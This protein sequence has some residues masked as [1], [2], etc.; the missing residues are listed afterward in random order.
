MARIG[1][2]FINIDTL[3]VLSRSESGGALADG[4]TVLDLTQSVVTFH[5]IARID[6]F[7][8]LLVASAILR[9]IFVLDTINAEAAYF[10]IVRIASGSWRAGARWLMIN[11]CTE[12]VTTAG[13]SRAGVGASF[14][15]AL[16][17]KT[18]QMVC[19]RG[20]GFTFVG[21]DASFAVAIANGSRSARAAER[22]ERVGTLSGRVTWSVQAF[23]NID[24][25]SVGSGSVARSATALAVSTD[26]TIGAIGI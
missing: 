3:V 21:C 16:T 19:T 26:L 5:R 1:A 7:E 10:R 4:F 2:A 12:G 23:V 15:A 24:A 8:R 13:R 20:A 25:N 17:D 11:D 14:G 22:S 18:S 9:T 6:A